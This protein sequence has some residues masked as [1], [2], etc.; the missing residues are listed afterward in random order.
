[1]SGEL[2]TENCTS[3][4]PE[5]PVEE[6]IYGYY[7]SLSANAW[8]AGF[9]GLCFFVNA[10]LGWRYRLWTY[11]LAMC[12]ATATSSA[13]YG[14]R[15]I[16]HDNPW[17]E[18][19]FMLQIITLTFSP[20]F[21][22]AAIYLTLKHVALRFG[23]FASRIPPRFYPW[24]FISAD[25][26]ALLLQS[27]GGGI[28]ASADDDLDLQEVG[29][30]LMIAGVVFQ[31]VTLAVFGAMIIDYTYR[32][33]KSPEP[34]SRKATET[35][36]DTKFRIF[37]ASLITLYTAI[38][39]RCVYRIAELA[40]GWESSIMQNEA[41]FIGLDTVMMTICTG[42]QTFVHPGIFF[43]AMTEREEDLSHGAG[44]FKG[45]EMS[46]SD[47]DRDRDSDSSSPDGQ[48]RG[49]VV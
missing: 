13:G 16:M 22:S 5:C 27:A 3:I 37:A 21:N 41:L 33:Y 20:A 31:V 15:I 18:P 35:W 26:V 32:R 9:F 19:G 6:T 23:S 29:D 34:L 8:G 14:G 39:I 2:N 1:M 46:M 48:R 4:S 38:L 49:G 40:G 30:G 24:G 42:L 45:G 17:D 12:L 36:T 7:P 11:M 47:S 43:S 10:Y 25:F 28:A 44:G